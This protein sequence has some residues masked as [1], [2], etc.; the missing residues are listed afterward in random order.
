VNYYIF[1]IYLPS[2]RF[3]ICFSAH[4]NYLIEGDFSYLGE[5]T[6]KAGYERHYTGYYYIFPK[7][8]N[9]ANVGIGRFHANKKGRSPHLRSEFDRV[10]RKEGLHRYVIHKK[11]SSFFPSRSVKRL[12]WENIILIGDA[13]A[14]CSPL[15]GGGIDMACISGRIAAELT[16]TV[17]RHFL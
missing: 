7:G 4:F 1:F 15:H 16:R 14:L 2:K 9:I 11:I 12:L 3:W 17:K 8:Q 6:L 5:N 13:A 10:L